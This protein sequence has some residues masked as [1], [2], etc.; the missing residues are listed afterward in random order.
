M[1]QHLSGGSKGHILLE[2]HRRDVGCAIWLRKSLLKP[3]TAR[4]GG[5]IP[6]ETMGAQGICYTQHIYSLFWSPSADV[7]ASASFKQTLSILHV[8][9]CYSLIVASGSLKTREHRWKENT[10]FLLRTMSTLS[11]LNLK[12]SVSVNWSHYGLAI[13]QS[14]LINISMLHLDKNLF[15]N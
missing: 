13:I 15:D 10:S 8:P 1:T 2:W 12:T 9:W 7:C 4:D 14:G 11:W 6:H 5:A 3:G